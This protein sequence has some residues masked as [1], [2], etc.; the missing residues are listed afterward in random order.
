MTRP[1][2]TALFLLLPLPTRAEFRAYQYLVKPRTQEAMVAAATART[3]VTSLNPVAYRAY[4][5]GS[6]VDVTLMRTWMCA[7]HT[8][9]KRVPCPAPGDREAP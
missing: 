5:G 7:G 1:L 9:R 6:S 3:V 2:L 8:G 4:H